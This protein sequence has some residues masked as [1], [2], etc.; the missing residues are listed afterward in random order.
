[1]AVRA[2]RGAIQVD[3]DERELVLGATTE[4]VTALFEANAQN[5]ED[6]ISL[7]KT[8]VAVTTT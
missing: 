2:V 1:V 4:L 6:V 5:P 7:D 3:A 8:G